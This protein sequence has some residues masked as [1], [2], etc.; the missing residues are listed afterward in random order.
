M[1]GTETPITPEVFD[2]LQA[3]M[4]ADRAGLTELYRDYLGDAW[5][6]LQLLREAVRQQRPQEAREK[7]HYLKSSSL[8]LGAREMARHASKIEELALATELTDELM[9]DRLADALTEVQAELAER[10]GGGVLPAGRT[11][12]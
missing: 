5:H 3:A 7:A 6:T 8:V 11:A 12:A 9:L 1:P 4:A 10:L 2:Q